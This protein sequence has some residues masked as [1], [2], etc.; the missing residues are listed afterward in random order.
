MLSD[1]MPMREWWR[2]QRRQ[3]IRLTI[4]NWQT[5]NGEHERPRGMGAIN[6]KA[7]TKFITGDGNHTAQNKHTDTQRKEK[8]RL[9]HITSHKRNATNISR[10]CRQV[11]NERT[12]KITNHSNERKKKHIPHV[13]VHTLT[14]MILAS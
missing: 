10:A 6:S 8:K 11:K 14:L 5:R 9:E 13:T 3:Q 12:N 4:T 7:E 2:R 1:S